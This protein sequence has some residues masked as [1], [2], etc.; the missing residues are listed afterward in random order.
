MKKILFFESEVLFSDMIKLKFEKA[1]IDVQCYEYPPEDGEELIN[2]VLAENP[3]LILT[4]IIMP[5]MDGYKLTE[6]LK[7]SE[8]T[9]HIPICAYTNLGE[10]ED[11]EKG[12]NLGMQDFFVRAN[13]DLTEIVDTIQKSLNK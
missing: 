1:G 5:V 4:E 6:I 8:K 13:I 3:D 7:S 9:K 10:K 2:L 12:I 11:R